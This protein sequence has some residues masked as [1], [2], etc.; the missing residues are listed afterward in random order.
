[1]H[2]AVLAR[3]ALP[4]PTVVYGLLMRPFSLGHELFLLREGNPLLDAQTPKGVTAV[5][6]AQAAL[7]CCQSWDENR[8]AAL[9]WFRR[10]KMALWRWLVRRTNIEREIWRF[11]AYRDE[12]QLEFRLSDVAKADKAT[13]RAPGTPFLLRLQQWLMLSL[14]LQEAEAWDYPA[15]LAKMRWAAYWE[16]EQGLDVYNQHDAEFDQFIAEQEA[17]GAE[18]V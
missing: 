2:E 1:M 3:A 8:G 9:D 13:P 5:H 14:R 7:I 15:G 6:L 11:I 12:G 16:Q 17:M 18:K 10:P 4:A